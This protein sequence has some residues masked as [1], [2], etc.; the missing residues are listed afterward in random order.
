MSKTILSEVEGF[1][2][3]I[4]VIAEELGLVPAAV[5]GRIWRYC[6]LRDGVCYASL[7]TLAS[8]LGLNKATVQR[9]AEK[10]VKA[11]YL[12]DMTPN[13]RNTPHTYADTGKVKMTTKV[14]VA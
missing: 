5:F 1:T 3:V 2:P 9:N 4:D 7:E 6:Q 13:L 14:S 11:G 12:I 10:L 8:G